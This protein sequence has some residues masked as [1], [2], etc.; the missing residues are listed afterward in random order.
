MRN[1]KNTLKQTILFV[2]ICAWMITP[3]MAVADGGEFY[4]SYL[5]TITLD[6]KFASRSVLTFHS[7]R[8][9]SVVDSAQI[10][11]DLMFSEQ[12]GAWKKH[13]N[14][15]I[16]QT[17]DFTFTPTPGL[18]RNDYDLIVDEQ[19]AK[20]N[21]HIELRIYEMDGDPLHD[22]GVLIGIYDL[23][24]TRLKIKKPNK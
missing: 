16:G 4:G 21:G 1:M 6:G 9:M 14:H 22:D 15:V 17:I 10:R 2:M 13:G 19:N 7:D 3:V 12:Q 8:T 11:Q 18:A 5:T 24:G 23:T 20:L